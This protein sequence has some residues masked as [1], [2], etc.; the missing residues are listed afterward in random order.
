MNGVRKYT[1]KKQVANYRGR[2]GGVE[3]KGLTWP[4]EDG[5]K[6]QYQGWEEVERK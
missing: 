1:E 2:R 4:Q 5:N 3:T 6:G